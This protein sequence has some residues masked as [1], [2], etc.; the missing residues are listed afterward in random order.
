MFKEKLQNTRNNFEITNNYYPHGYSFEEISCIDLTIAH[1]LGVYQK[2]YYYYYCFL[3][4]LYQ[5]FYNHTSCFSHKEKSKYILN[6]LNF[7]F[8]KNTKFEVLNFIEDSLKN[9]EPVIFYTN[10]SCLFFSNGY[11]KNNQ[12][13][14]NFLITSYDKD[15]QIITIQD[16]QIVERYDIKFTKGEIYYK[17]RI[18]V[19][20]FLEIIKETK[21][22]YG[23]TNEQFMSKNIL[24]I[25]QLNKTSCISENF[26]L[27]EFHKLKNNS[28]NLLNIKYKFIDLKNENDI[29]KF[30]YQTKRDYLKGFEIILKFIENTFELKNKNEY[31]TLT[32]EILEK[33][34]LY[35]T[36]CFKSILN[37]KNINESKLFILENEIKTIKDSLFSSF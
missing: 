11:K 34:E 29:Y 31:N 18:K 13:S 12:S 7:T 28:L 37:C 22:F 20:S 10:Y 35:I 8:V 33:I 36:I 5:N 16:P 23:S 4:S 26:L 6:L 2:E 27:S 30:F 3:F 17:S 32:Q 1:A 21:E 15:N 25:S 9:N 14:H 24:K 19:N